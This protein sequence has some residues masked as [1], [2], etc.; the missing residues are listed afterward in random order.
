MRAG[1]GFSTAGTKTTLLPLEPRFDYG[2]GSLL[3]KPGGGHTREAEECDPPVFLEPP[4][5]HPFYEGGPPPRSASRGTVSDRHAM[6]KRRVNHTAPQHP[7][8]FGYQGGSHPPPKPLAPRSFLTTSVTSPG[9]ERSNPKS[10]ASVF[11]RGKCVIGQ[12]GGNPRVLLP[13]PGG[14]DGFARI[15]S[16]RPGVPSPCLTKLPPGPSFLP[17]PQPGARSTL[18]PKRYPVSRLRSPTSQP[19]PIGLLPFFS[20]TASLTA[21]IHH[22]VFGIAAVTGQPQTLRPQLRAAASTIDA[23]NM[24]HS[25]SMSPTSPGIWSKLS[26]RWELNTSL[27]E[28]SS[29]PSLCAWA[30]Q[31]CP[32]FSS[33]SG[34]NSPPGGDQWTAQPLS[35]PEC[36]KHAAEGLAPGWDPGS[37][38]PGYVTGLDLMVVMKDS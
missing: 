7:E 13:P 31:V 23:E 36:P 4:P 18:G 19:Q 25:D 3:S 11:L 33:S 15:A 35:S 29:R 2:A 38:V 37:A 32:A 10:P 21:G 12:D 30:C 28:G 22:R 5:G 17:L 20:L 34:S 6:L 24:V 14:P 16:G 1:P 9:C 26:R 8:I 27:A